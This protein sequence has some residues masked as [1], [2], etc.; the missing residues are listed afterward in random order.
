[1]SAALCG[2]QLETDE[3]LNAGYWSYWCLEGSAGECTAVVGK[4]SR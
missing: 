4:V 1:M 2:R 3:A